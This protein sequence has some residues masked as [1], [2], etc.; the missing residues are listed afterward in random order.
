MWGRLIDRVTRNQLPLTFFHFHSLCQFVACRENGSREATCLCLVCLNEEQEE[1]EKGNGRRRTVSFY[2]LLLFPF[3]PF[4]SWVSQSSGAFHAQSVGLSHAYYWRQG[5]DNGGKVA[6]PN[7]TTT[8][9]AEI[10]CAFLDASLELELERERQL[11]PFGCWSVALHRLILSF[12][13]LF[14][15]LRCTCHNVLLLPASVPTVTVKDPLRPSLTAPS[16]VLSCQWQ[17]WRY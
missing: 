11:T 1:K 8:T 15:P 2:S 4:F 7:S 13:C 10:K 14:L 12:P 9:T 16:K 3:L 6:R 17:C 5:I